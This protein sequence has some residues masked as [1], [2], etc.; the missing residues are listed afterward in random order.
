MS[1]TLV[2][3]KIGNYNITRQ[4]GEGGMGA[5]YLGEHPLIGKKVAVK[6]LHDDLATKQDIVQRFFTEAKAVNDIHHENIVDI[7]DFGQMKDDSGKELVYFLMELLEGEPLSGRLKKGQMT[8]EESVHVLEQC[9]SALA[10][11]HAKNIVHRDLK[12]DNIYLVHRGH[13]TNF[14][15][16][17]DFGIAKL[18]GANAASG[19]TRAGAVIGTPAYMSPEQ[20]DGRGNIDHRSDI[21][22]LGVVMFEMLCGRVPFTGDGFGEVLVA[23]LTLPPPRPTEI[24]PN[25]PPGLEAIVLRCLEKGRDQRF[26]TMDELRDALVNSGAYVPP[27]PLTGYNKIIDTGTAPTMMPD[28]MQAPR[29]TTLSG[30]AGEVRPGTG[31]GQAPAPRSKAPLFAA[32]G[33]V[34]LGGGGAGAYFATRKPPEPP[35]PQLPLVVQ[36]KEEKV[37]ILIDSTP[38]GADVKRA[39]HADPVGKTPYTVELSKGGP[40]FDVMVTLAGYKVE[41]KTVIPD[42]DHDYLLALGKEDAP[43]PPP[44]LPPPTTPEKKVTSSSHHHHE[45]GGMQLLTDDEGKGKDK[46][47]EKK[48][49]RDSSDPDGVLMPEL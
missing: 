37:H 24:N 21:Y 23:Q 38:Q 11:S 43:P 16:L 6:V 20:C 9:C 33:L 35:K 44:N 30:S 39:G 10:A 7:V 31:S 13:D 1:A 4:L 42:R 2:G 25:V 32:L 34:V 8:P 45:E 41:T 36:P 26:Q 12:P 3:K 49:K 46:K 29:P 14:V 5:V 40:S 15:K 17:L 28:Q 27:R 19:M 47:E 48:K 22:S 18:T